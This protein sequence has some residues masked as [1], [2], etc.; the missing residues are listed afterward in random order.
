VTDRDL[1]MACYTQGRPL[2]SIPVSWVL[3]GRVHV[4]SPT[5][6]LDHAIAL[7]RAHRVRRLVVVD[8][9]QRV[10]GVLSLAD[11]AR[12]V[13]ALGPTEPGAPLVLSRLLAG[14][15]ERRASSAERVSG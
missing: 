12:H 9:R 13:A 4:C 3:S 7:M 8:A 14:L 11:V 10:S 5:D 2:S 1:C 6:T 15:S